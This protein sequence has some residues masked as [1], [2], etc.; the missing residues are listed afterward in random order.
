[1]NILY[2]VQYFNRPDEPGGSRAY[3]FARRWTEAGHHVTVLTGGI[4]HKTGGVF[5]ELKG[6]LR[7]VSQN[8]GVEVIRLRSYAGD[9]GAMRLRYVNFLS[10]AASAAA[11]GSRLPRPDLVFASSTPLTVGLA[12]AVLAR[13]QGVPL[14]F[15]VRDLWPKAAV[16]AGVLKEGALVSAASALE[17]W[18]YKEARQTIVVSEGDRSELVERGLRKDRVHWV[19][20]GVD[21]WMIADVPMPVAPRRGPLQVFYVGAHGRWNHLD[22]LL[23]I[24]EQLDGV[25]HFTLVGDGDEKTRLVAEAGKRRLSNVT[26]EAAVPKREA[27]E[28][29]RAADATIVISGAHEHYDQ[30]LPNKIFDYMAAGRPVIVVGGGELERLV[31]RAGCGVSAAPDD[32]DRAVRCIRELAEASSDALTK[33]G[34]AGYDLV[35]REFS[36]NEHADRLL[37]LLETTVRDNG[38]Y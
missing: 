38:A 6:R 30:W 36:R 37:R 15:E 21:D 18:L 12:G 17:R 25:A 4:N 5:P 9:R 2:L 16:V 24:A 1:M 35:V 20:N 28:R 3:Q 13:L 33:M 34:R 23:D 14:V 19:P 32:M 10:Y 11:F 7:H 27:F 8:N 31:R 22:R 26:F 29:L